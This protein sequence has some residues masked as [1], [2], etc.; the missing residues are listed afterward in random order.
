[1]ELCLAIHEHVDT[2]HGENSSVVFTDIDGNAV[3]GEK[4][5]SHALEAP[6]AVLRRD[7][8]V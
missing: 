2:R 3:S 7:R 6:P 1:M 5:V 4:T 8:G